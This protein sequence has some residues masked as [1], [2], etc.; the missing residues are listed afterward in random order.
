MLDVDRLLCE[1]P[2]C[3]LD[4]LDATGLEA[5]VSLLFFFF[6]DT[7]PTEIYTLSL[8]DAFPISRVR[9]D[10]RATREPRAALPALDPAQPGVGG[11]RRRAHDRALGRALGAGGRARGAARCARRSEE[12]PA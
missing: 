5:E 4:S 2:V 11:D 1:M 9:A 8:H 7:A 6:N 12:H 10:P 3:F